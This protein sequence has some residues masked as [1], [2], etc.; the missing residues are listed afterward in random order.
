MKIVLYKWGSNSE[1]LLKKTLTESGHQIIEC[2][3]KCKHYTRDLELAGE[4]MNM[5]H[6]VGADAIISYNYFP[7]IS[8]VCNTIGIPYYSWV[9][10]SP[11]YTLFAK[12]VGYDCNHIG[13]FDGAMV[14]YLNDI[15]IKSVMHLPLGSDWKEDIPVESEY[16]CDISFV[17]SLYSDTYNYYE[18]I[19]MPDTIRERADKYIECHRF[20]YDRDIPDTFFVNDKNA[21]DTL[22]TDELRNILANA[23]L[24]PGE[25]YTEDVEYIFRASVLEKKV[26]VDERRILLE[27]VAGKGYDFRLY[28][29]SDLSTLPLLKRANRGYIDYN[30]IMPVVFRNSRINLN[31]T[32]R[33]IH[34]GIPLR[35]L[36]IMGCGGFLLSNYQKELG[37]IFEDGKEVVMFRSVEDCIEKIDYY[38]EHEEERRQIAHNGKIA[39]GEKLGLKEQLN[40]LL[41]M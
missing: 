7:I 15:G 39:V 12:T 11:H 41:V 33:S 28:T 38:L 40:K 26:T 5:V 9:Y 36:D 18:N 27:Q 6:G 3:T 16:K 25:D 34:T 17:G 32:L 35:A 19:S 29:G 10:D 2:S 21:K 8:M 31:M 14:S 24:L 4:L 20:I 22:L 13:I 23:G 37:E 1:T 30:S